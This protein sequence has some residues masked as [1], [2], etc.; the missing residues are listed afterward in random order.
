M[1]IPLYSLFLI[2][3]VL[4]T[5]NVK[6][7]PKPTKEWWKDSFIYQIY[8]RSFMDSNGDGVG[9]LNG[10][11]SKLEHFVDLNVS[12]IW[13]SPIYLS[14]MVDFGY[15]IS[16]FTDVDPV[17]GTLTDFTNLTT[18]A[19]TLGLKVILDF[20]PNHSSDKHPW[21][22]NS[23][24]KIKPYDDYY[25]WM[26][27]KLV[28]G[29]TEPPNNWLSVFGGSAW[30][31]NEERGQYYLHQFASGQPDLNYRSAALNLEMAN[32]LTF[33]LDHG[34][35]GF[36]ID[37]INFLF[38]DLKYLDEPVIINSGLPDNDYDSLVHIYSKDQSDTFAI[39]ESWRKL[40]D[41]HGKKATKGEP[42][43]ILTEA[44]TSLTNTM[45]YYTAG[46]NVP[47]N[48]MFMTPLNNRSTTMDFKRN[49]DAWINNV[50][51]GSLPNWVIGNHDQ[52]RVATRYGT[53]RADGFPMLAA[54]LPG[55][56]IVYYGDEIGMTDR[57][58]TWNETVD[59]AGC[60]AGQNRYYLKSR[61]PARTPYQWDNTTNA[62]FSVANVTW[63]PV[64]SNYKTLNLAAE[65][66]NP[67]SHYVLFKKLVALKKLP[68]MAS[69]T[70]EVIL[71]KETILG[72]VRRFPAA[73]PVVLLINFS[74]KTDVVDARTWMN[75]PEQLTV[76][77]SSVGSNIPSDVRMD[78]TEIYLP[79][80]ASV[81]LTELESSFL[82]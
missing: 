51:K 5:I 9:D 10:I 81:I 12:A 62:G 74:D 50:P 23:I 56:G 59:P 33:W 35:D 21:F 17:F 18:K 15:D 26:D 70:T 19:K 38:E 52:H 1:S 68:I 43:I 57:P 80:G 11:T 46:S 29:T 6:A 77:V 53:K 32:V 73:P 48:F 36:R 13:I 58:M 67:E 39:L 4:L 44:Y 66:I 22:V 25:I 63:L 41:T 55:L 76:F 2:I 64:N 37:A 3:I 54:V 31:F 7:A 49:I 16:N 28:N 30:E 40:I 8:P 45:L 47:M 69:A 79:A 27:G 60:N 65:K 14:P 34:V 75:I 20:V 82:I 78:T 72:V 24:K 61:D 42:K 71:V